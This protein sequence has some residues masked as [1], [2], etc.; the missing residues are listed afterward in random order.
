[1]T[2][3]ATLKVIEEERSG[4]SNVSGNAWKMRSVVLE[5][6]EQAAPDARRTQRVRATMFGPV[7]EEFNRSG[8]QIGSAVSVDLDFTTSSAR[9]GYVYNEVRVAAIQL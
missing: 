2:I 9:N 3:K 1:M 6:T 7:C 5:W 8:V 4:I